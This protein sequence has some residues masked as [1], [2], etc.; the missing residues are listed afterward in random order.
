MPE[1]RSQLAELRA[2]VSKIAETHGCAIIAASTH[3]FLNGKSSFIRIAN[4]VIF[5]PMIYKPWS[6][7]C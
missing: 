4:A 5:W 3:P 1:A 7:G 6:G 2:T